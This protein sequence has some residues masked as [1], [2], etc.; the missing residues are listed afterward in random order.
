[1]KKYI[2]RFLVIYLAYLLLGVVQKPLF[3]LFNGG[4]AVSAADWL[5]AIWHGLPMDCTMAGYLTLVPA[6]LMIAALWCPGNKWI[7]KIEHNYFIWSVVIVGVCAS[8]NTVLYGYWQFP[9]D[10]TPFFYFSTSPGAARASASMTD[11]VVSFIVFFCVVA[12]IGYF[13]KQV[14]K[15]H[16]IDVPHSQRAAT[17]GVAALMLALLFIPIRGGFTVATMN[18]GRAY[19]CDR[20]LLNHAGV[21]PTF[22]VIYSLMHQNNFGEQFRYLPDPEAGRVFQRM[23]KPSA[24]PAD[25]IIDGRPDIYLIIAESFS[26]HLLPSL[27]GDSVAVKLDSLAINGLLFDNFYASSFRTDRALPAILG[28]L[29]AQPNT[30]LMKFPAKLHGYTLPMALADNGYGL[31]YFYGG[32]INFTNMKAYIYSQQFDGVVCDQDFPPRQRQSKWGVHDGPLFARAWDHLKKTE[33]ANPQLLVIQT[34]SSHEPFEVPHAGRHADKRL[35]AFAYTDSCI[36]AFVDSVCTLDRPSLV[37]IVPDHYGCWP[38]DL[39]GEQQRHRIPLIFCGTALTERGRRISRY[40]GQTDIAATVLG[41]LGIDASPFK[42]SR[43][44]LGDIPEPFAFYS[45]PNAFA[46]SDST[47][48]ATVEIATGR[49]EGDS[50]LA[51]KAKAYIQTLFDYLDSL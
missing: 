48:T 40:G 43:D 2:I 26:A 7:G 21:N 1:M 38:A 17:T 31:Y 32:D 19:F 11:F 14:C 29:P 39:E 24:T 33:T 8:L 13:F 28:A 36:G 10:S 25:T 50:I 45:S 42:F 30:S 37:V 41:Q 16:K 6:L 27:G 18:P 12:P 20:P 51:I 22:S 5:A 34:S 49:V 23:H 47:G 44:M 35:N 46:I 9:L 3:L 4:T 15:R